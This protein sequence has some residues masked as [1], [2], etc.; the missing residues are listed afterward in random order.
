VAGEEQEQ[1]RAADPWEDV[2]SDLLDTDDDAIAVEDIWKKLGVE[3]NNRDNRHAD[4]VA[5]I[6]QRHGFTVKAKIRRGGPPAKYWLRG[7][8]AAANAAGR[9]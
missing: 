2:L 1:R 3:A 7:A 9:S 5:A 4:R 6:M 8:A